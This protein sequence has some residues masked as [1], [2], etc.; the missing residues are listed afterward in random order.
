MSGFFVVQLVL[1][2]VLFLQCVAGIASAC[3]PPTVQPPALCG[4]R[5]RDTRL[6]A[7]GSRNHMQ[8]F[9]LLSKLIDFALQ[10][11]CKRF[12]AVS[13][14]DKKNL[15]QPSIFESGNNLDGE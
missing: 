3:S 13:Q 6:N 7:V 14:N 12:L 2:V 4:V 1:I 9:H 5:Q 11:R 8:L 15:K 10:A